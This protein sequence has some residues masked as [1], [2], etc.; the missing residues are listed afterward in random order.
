MVVV[1]ELGPS[2]GI[3]SE[4][5][6]TDRRDEIW[7]CTRASPKTSL[8]SRLQRNKVSIVHESASS[9]FPLWMI[10][11]RGLRREERERGEEEDEEG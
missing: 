8:C 5:T 6:V 11:S 2:F 1:G 4:L 10:V 9:F 7:C 3:F